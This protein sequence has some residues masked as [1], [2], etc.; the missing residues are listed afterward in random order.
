MAW[1]IPCEQD[2]RASKRYLAHFYMLVQ[3]HSRCYAPVISDER[4]GQ[5]ILIYVSQTTSACAGVIDR[6]DDALAYLLGVVNIGGNV[7]EGSKAWPWPVPPDRDMTVLMV[8]IFVP[9]LA[10]VL[11]SIACWKIYHERGRHLYQAS[12]CALRN[13]VS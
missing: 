13:Q 5:W 9:T 8:Y 4:N 2:D 12:S 11:G 1:P 3:Q 6:A 10:A 7:V